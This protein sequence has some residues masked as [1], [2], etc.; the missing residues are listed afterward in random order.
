MSVEFWELTLAKRWCW[1]FGSQDLTRRETSLPSMSLTT[2]WIVTYILRPGV[3]RPALCDVFVR[4]VMNSNMT[5]DAAQLKTFVGSLDALGLKSLEPRI[6]WGRSSWTPD[7]LNQD[8]GTTIASSWKRDRVASRAPSEN[9][10]FPTA[11]RCQR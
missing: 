2:S 7:P 9:M 5:R 4:Q 6:A 8:I 1:K 3:L 10:S 11:V